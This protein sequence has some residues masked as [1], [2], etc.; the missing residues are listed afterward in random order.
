MVDELSTLSTNC[1]MKAVKILLTLIAA[2]AVVVLGFYTYLGGW[3]TV[4]VTR[5]EM[6]SM[7][8]VYSL[9]R[10]AYKDLHKSWSRFK[11]EWEAAGLKECDALAVYLDPPG[12]PDE[13]LRSVI[14]CRVDSLSKEEKEKIKA[15]LPSF[16]IPRSAALLSSFPYRNPASYF[17]GPSKVYPAF[18]KELTADKIIPP[19]A[20]ETYGSMSK[21][22]DQI[23]FAMPLESKRTDYAKLM[24]AF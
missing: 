18:Q 2:L 6:P 3:S 4:Q 16:V 19:V 23:G 1:P 10:G 9:H 21:P 24:E 14:A 15:K 7:E 17:V 8:I 11:G 20:I 13:K 12:T 22:A 5:G